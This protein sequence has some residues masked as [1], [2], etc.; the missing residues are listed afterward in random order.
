MFP[1]QRIDGPGQFARDQQENRAPKRPGHQSRA[2]RT[3]VAGMADEDRSDIEDAY[4]DS[5]SPGDVGAAA[6]ASAKTDAHREARR[7]VLMGGLTPA[8]LI[9]T[10]DSL[11]ALAGGGGHRGGGETLGRWT[12]LSRHTSP[13]HKP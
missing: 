7:R 13:T 2:H 8:P 12:L 10:L 11:P 1:V 4:L 6:D 5:Q 3:R 9:M